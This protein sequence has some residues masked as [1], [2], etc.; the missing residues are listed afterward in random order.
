MAC[1]WDSKRVSFNRDQHSNPWIL[2]LMLNLVFISILRIPIFWGYW[3]EVG[4]RAE[5]RGMF[6]HAYEGLAYKCARTIE[7][8]KPCLHVVHA[9]T[10]G[11]LPWMYCMYPD[12]VSSL[13]IFL[14][15]LCFGISKHNCFARYVMWIHVYFVLC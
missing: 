6:V 8:C 12:L 5:L 1:R 2:R 9:G 4:S 7:L 10:L 14:V 3:K 11:W 15:L 13:P